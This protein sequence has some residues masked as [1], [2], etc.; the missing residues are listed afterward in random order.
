[1]VMNNQ[2]S[3]CGKRLFLG[4][5]QYY[6]LHASRVIRHQIKDKSDG[7]VEIGIASVAAIEC[8]VSIARSTI[9]QQLDSR[10]VVLGM[11]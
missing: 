10:R 5:F 7:G 8:G 2:G 3:V 9:G 4:F 6:L 1:M 11:F